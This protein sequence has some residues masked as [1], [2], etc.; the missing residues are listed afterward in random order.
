MS[1]QYKAFVGQSLL[2]N[3]NDILGWAKESEL[4]GSS[5]IPHIVERLSAP[6]IEND[7]C[8]YAS[9]LTAARLFP[10]ALMP[11]GERLWDPWYGPFAWLIDPYGVPEDIGK[12][13]KAALGAAA[14]MAVMQQDTTLEVGQVTDLAREQVPMSLLS[15][16]L[17]DP[18]QDTRFDNLRQAMLDADRKYAETDK[19]ALRAKWHEKAVERV[20]EKVTLAAEKAKHRAQKSNQKKRQENTDNTEG[21]LDDRPRRSRIDI[22]KEGDPDEAQTSTATRGTQAS[23]ADFQLGRKLFDWNLE[24]EKKIREQGGEIERLQQELSARAADHHKIAK[25]E[26]TVAELQ[27]QLSH[28]S[29]TFQNTQNGG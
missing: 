29:N 7:G 11:I 12:H 17:L 24:L 4:D 13:M 6:T 8:K 1:D 23:T 2:D 9:I 28:L 15:R 20:D 22:T 14:T 3:Y 27:Q 26:G 25:L 5:E 16:I 18:P 21:H 10:V 19:D